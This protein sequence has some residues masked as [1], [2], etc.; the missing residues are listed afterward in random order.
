M[1][2]L[3]A[4]GVSGLLAV[5]L[6]GLVLLFGP[7]AASQNPEPE[8]SGGCY[9]NSGEKFI[10]Y[11]TSASECGPHET[12]VQLGGTEGP[13]GQPGADGVPE[14]EQVRVQSAFNSNGNKRVTASCP[15]GKMVLGGGFRLDGSDAFGSLLV[16]ENQPL[17]K[18]NGWTV[19]VIEK[20]AT[21]DSWTA[22]AYAMCAR[23]ATTP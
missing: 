22:E 3:K 18:S 17:S 4:V 7:Q 9:R 12:F 14:L 10:R 2:R 1:K 15:T 20:P 8:V 13:P 19:L 23:P 11:A 16:L 5:G 21:F 6:L